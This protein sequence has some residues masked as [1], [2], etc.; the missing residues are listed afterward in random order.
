MILN[1][2]QQNLIM[3]ILLSPVVIFNFFVSF[4]ISFTIWGPFQNFGDRRLIS[5]LI[6]N[7]LLLLWS[8]QHYIS[9]QPMNFTL[10]T[11]LLN[12]LCFIN[13]FSH[14]TG[15]VGE[16]M[17]YRCLALILVLLCA[18]DDLSTFL[19]RPVILRYF[20]TSASVF[21]LFTSGVHE[22]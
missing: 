20:Y 3:K 5:Q 2:F 11:A 16:L 8:F 14:Q 19:I 12:S 17:C 18:L 1:H 22:V 6:K 4:S 21:L 13:L 9:A 10:A 7:V 15:Q